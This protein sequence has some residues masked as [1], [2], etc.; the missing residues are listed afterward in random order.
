L[1]KRITI[2]EIAEKAKVS[3]GTV[4]RVLHNRGEVSAKTRE[5]VLK[6]AREGNY[7]PNLFARQLVLNRSFPIIS[8]VPKHQQNE[9]W[10]FPQTG[11]MNAAAELKAFGVQNSTYLFDEGSAEDFYHTALEALNARPA[12]IL[13]APVIYEKAMWLAEECRQQNIPLVLIDSDLPGVHKLASISQDAFQSGVL[14]AKLIHY[15]RGLGTDNAGKLYLLSISL[16]QDNNNVIKQRKKGFLSYFKDHLQEADIKEVSFKADRP[17]F[18]QDLK[19]FAAMLNPGDAVCA[20]NS[21][22]HYLAAELEKSSKAGQ[23]RVIG[24]D[25]TGRNVSFLEKGIIDFL[26]NQKP[27]LQGF[28]GIQAL[29][30]HLVLKQEVEERV[31]MPLEIITRENVRF[32]S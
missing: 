4:D 10:A 12:G 15:S 9:Y 19:Q 1:E 14:A 3:P 21:K 28:M 6:I 8:I 32:I 2:R 23:V 26:I 24:Y 17:D 16:Q 25:L 5:K 20:P 30:K 7:E 29:Y 22:V 27:E 18:K 11:I 13:L 31:F